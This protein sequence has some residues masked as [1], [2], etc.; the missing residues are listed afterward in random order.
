[1]ADGANAT[2]PTKELELARSRALT[3]LNVELDTPSRVAQRKFQ[4]TVYPKDHPFHTFPEDSLKGISRE[5][6]VV[7]IRDIIVR[8]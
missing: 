3:A 2:F 1:L 5:D 7:F 4:Q 6:V 8:I